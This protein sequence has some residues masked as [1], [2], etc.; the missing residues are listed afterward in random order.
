DIVTLNYGMLRATESTALP[1]GPIKEMRMELTG[2]MDRYLWAID[3]KTVSETDRILIRKGENV[4][5][6]LFNKSMMRHR[7]HLHGHFCRVINGNG[8]RSPLEN[9]LDIMPMETATIEF[10]GTDA[11]AWF[12]HCHLLYPMMTG[13]G[14]VFTCE[15]S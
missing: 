10:A 7:M 4:R 13:M 5:I 2:N 11:G 1:P 3:N 15:S 12:F 14:R 9:L 6:I 8:D